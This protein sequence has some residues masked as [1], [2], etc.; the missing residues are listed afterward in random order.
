MALVTE[1]SAAEQ[2]F[3][4]TPGDELL[5]TNVASFQ[6]QMHTQL[7]WSSQPFTDD[8][9]G[10]FVNYGDERLFNAPTPIYFKN[11]YTAKPYASLHLHVRAV[12]L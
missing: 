10:S 3:T 8:N 7:W 2:H 4:I 11:L 1:T 12:L 6:S 9:K 5:V